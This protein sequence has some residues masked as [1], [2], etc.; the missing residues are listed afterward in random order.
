MTNGTVTSSW[1]YS[2]LGEETSYT[3]GAAAEVEYGYD[4]AGNQTSIT[5]PNGD[6]VVQVF[7]DA[8]EVSSI[9][10]WNGNESSFS[11]DA[12]GNLTAEDLANGVTNSYTYDPANNLASISDTKGETS[13]FS[14]TYTRNAD[15]LVSEDSSQP[16]DSSKYQYTGLSQVCYAAS[17][18]GSDCSSPPDGATS[19]SYDAS[20][21]LTDDDGTQQE[22][23]DGDELCWSV[24]GTSDGG[25]DTA[26]SGATTYTYDD[27]GNLTA[28]TPA[29]ASAASL[30]YNAADELS[31]YQLGS[32]AVISYAYDGDGLRVSET[33]SDTTT[34]FTWN[35]S[36]PLP[37]LI[38]K[39]TGSDTTSYIDGPSGLPLE[40]INPDGDTYYY[41]QDNLGST[42]A[43]TNSSGDLADTDTYDS[44]GNVTAST[45]SVAD[46][47]LFSGQYMDTESGLYYLLARYYD[48][49]TGQ[50]L[51]VD[52]L[53]QDTQMPYAYASGDPINGIDPSG[54]DVTRAEMCE[55]LT[56]LACGRQPEV[57]WGSISVGLCGSA[58]GVVRLVGGFL[59]ICPIVLRFQDGNLAGVGSTET[60]GGGI[61]QGGAIAGTVGLSVA[62]P[63]RIS[64]LGN[65]FIY[66]EGAA[67]A[68]PTAA[69]SRAQG[70]ETCGTRVDVWSAGVGT[71]AG[72]SYL[73]G[74]SW[75]FTQTWWGS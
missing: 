29:S 67:G 54:N 25:C 58:L 4:L 43:L 33:T 22:F 47:M 64:D 26:P 51:S 40:E 68:G 70:R 71:G 20:G 52:P 13:I 11:Y 50:F 41:S 15:S 12:N 30:D 53:V 56:T 72:L 16:S 60:V 37:L 24:S 23:N 38:Q 62:D 9:T 18:N 3:N 57:T 27:N 8:N 75:T 39:T 65:F 36:G 48:P 19:Y 74:G 32:G 66:A 63:S 21:N 55:K 42:R 69:F 6:L 28:I 1:T 44:Y 46:A 45:G 10:D 73:A 35:D 34:Q 5:Y 49:S 59:T 2:S 61:G 17:S 31:G 14:A 7:N